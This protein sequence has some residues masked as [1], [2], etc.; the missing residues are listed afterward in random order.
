MKRKEYI[1][2]QEYFMGIAL[3]SSKRSK[4]PNTQVGA[5]IVN[6]EKKIVGIGYNGFPIGISD[7]EFPWDNEKEDE[8]DNKYPYVCHAELNAILNSQS[9]TKECSIYVTLFPCNECMKAII[10]SK[11]KKVYYLNDKGFDLFYEITSLKM[12]KAVGIECQKI[13]FKEIILN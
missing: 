6:K 3:L 10:Q 2:W 4:D 5:C 9:S 12:A 7:D 11:I 8:V 1:N 13:E